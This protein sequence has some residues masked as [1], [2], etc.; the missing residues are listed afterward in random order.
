MLLTIGRTGKITIFK[1]MHK[2]KHFLSFTHNKNL[3][4]S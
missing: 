3:E 4:Q 1:T 2:G